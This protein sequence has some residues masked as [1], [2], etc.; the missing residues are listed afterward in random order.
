ME[1]SGGKLRNAA[2]SGNRDPL[3]LDN[4]RFDLCFMS[5]TSAITGACKSV[6]LA[7]MVLQFRRYPNNQNFA[8]DF[9]CSIRAACETNSTDSVRASREK[10]PQASTEASPKLKNPP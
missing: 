6:L 7:L 10:L 2:R 4:R 5:A 3:R 8:F 1:S 9:G